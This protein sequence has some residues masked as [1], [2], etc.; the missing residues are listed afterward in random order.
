M[1]NKIYIIIMIN[2]LRYMYILTIYDLIKIDLFYN[3]GKSFRFFVG[4]ILCL[5]ILFLFFEQ[6][7]HFIKQK[8]HFTIT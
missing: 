6:L 5:I 1:D 4:T 2:E 3:K 7:F 8:M